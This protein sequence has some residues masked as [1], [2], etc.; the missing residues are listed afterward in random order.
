MTDVVTQLRH[1]SD[2]PTY[3]ELKRNLHTF[4]YLDS[5]GRNYRFT[6]A[7]TDRPAIVP[8][9]FPNAAFEHGEHFL[10]VCERSRGIVVVIHQPVLARI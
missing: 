9:A 4:P 5:I 6:C 1:K 7:G 3:Q 2:K 8:S 10:D